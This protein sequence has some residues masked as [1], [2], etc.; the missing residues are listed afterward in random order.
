MKK[1]LLTAALS[2]GLAL[3]GQYASANQKV[4]PGLKIS[5]ECVTDLQENIILTVEGHALNASLFLTIKQDFQ[6]KLI[7][8]GLPENITVEQAADR[9]K[10]DPDITTEQK[11]DFNT[12]YSKLQNIARAMGYPEGNIPSFDT[13]IAD[14]LERILNI[15]GSQDSIQ[16]SCA[17]KDPN[18]CIKET[19]KRSG[20]V[21]DYHA[22]INARAS[23][24]RS[25]MV[26]VALETPLSLISSPQEMLDY[27]NADTQQGHKHSLALESEFREAFKNYNSMLEGINAG[28]SFKNAFGDVY[29]GQRELSPEEIIDASN[30]AMSKALKAAIVAQKG[31]CDL[32]KSLLD[33]I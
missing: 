25:A 10:D 2:V 33:E 15:S 12:F 5:K 31:D 20:D 32:A 26:N 24:L 9:I 7:A 17:Y 29:S 8:M 28:N 18:A 19:I 3:S 1:S 6:E 14:Y 4:T 22:D 30:A 27:F 21:Y 23:A 13:I 16:D 11:N